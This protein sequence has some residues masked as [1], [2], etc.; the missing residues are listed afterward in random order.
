MPEAKE[1]FAALCGA[2]RAL[3]FV[4]APALFQ[5]AAGRCDS[6]LPDLA[7]YEENRRLLTEGLVEAGYR[8]AP[9]DGAFYLFVK[10]PGGDAVA[11]SEKAKEYEL[12]L[13][14]GDDF[15]APG[16]VRLAYCVKKETILRSLPAFRA[17]LDSYGR[18][19]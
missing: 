6:I 15:G 4:C 10:A 11:F 5:F 7:A 2:G 14:P 9:P 16:W 18:E 8:I 13:V 17:L 3:G 12:L 19:K 1:V